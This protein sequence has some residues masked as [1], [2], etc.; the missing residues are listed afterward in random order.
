MGRIGDRP[1]LVNVFPST[2]GNIVEE[3]LELGNEYLIIA[4]RQG[5][6]DE[7]EVQIEIG[8]SSKD[9]DRAIATELKGRL[10][11]RIDVCQVPKGTLARSNY[12]GKRASTT[13]VNK[14]VTWDRETQVLTLVNCD[15]G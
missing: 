10:N 11:L 1:G 7:L 3:F 6:T 5:G 13:D 12:K 8:P 14:S 2:V 9:I 15:Q 4:Y